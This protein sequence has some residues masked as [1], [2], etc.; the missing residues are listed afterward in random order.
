VGA[1]DIHVAREEIGVAAVDLAH[2]LFTQ[3]GHSIFFEK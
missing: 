1:G 2:F 3:I